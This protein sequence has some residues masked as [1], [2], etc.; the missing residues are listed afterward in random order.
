[1]KLTALLFIASLAFSQPPQTR[2]QP[3]KGPGGQVLHT[4][5]VYSGTEEVTP[6]MTK[7]NEAQGWY[8]DQDQKVF[9]HWTPL[10]EREY[11][12]FLAR[13]HRRPKR[14][15]LFPRRASRKD[16]LKAAPEVKQEYWRTRR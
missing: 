9:H 14:L 8:W 3:K 2:P 16:F 6:A 4:E 13:T 12:A 7:A 11:N 15:L 5:A 1:M 10:E